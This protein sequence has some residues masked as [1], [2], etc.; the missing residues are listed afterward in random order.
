MQ[1]NALR[2]PPFLTNGDTIGL[3][4]TA[5]KISI[6]EVAVAVQLFESWGLKVKMGKTLHLQN[7]QFAGTDEERTQDFQQMMDDDTVQ[8]IVC[9]RGGYGTVRM[10]DALDFTKYL[11]KPKWICGYSDI[12]VLHCHLNFALGIQSLHSTM[13]INFASNSPEALDSLRKALFGEPL[14]YKIPS[15]SFNV[16]GAVE[17]IITGGNLSVLYSLT[18]TNTLFSNTNHIL[19]LE[20]LDEYLYHIDRMMMNLKRG[21]KLNKLA[22]IIIGAFSDIKDNQIPF[23]KDAYQIIVDYAT[24][25]GI[26]VCYG[27]PC[28]H[29]PDNRTLIFGKKARLSID[30]NF[31][32]LSFF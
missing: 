21:A 30:H 20:D 26:P 4:A 31:T 18:G 11:K 1:M 23:G 2:Q 29:I 28:G 6:E 19:F 8:A 12:T 3:V 24:P 16:Q 13:P 5:K 7:N 10:I 22:G 32:E 27:F 15:N 17:S 14:S 9:A 25:L